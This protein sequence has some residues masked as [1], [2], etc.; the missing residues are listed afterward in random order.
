LQHLERL[1]TRILEA[2]ERGLLRLIGS[3]RGGE[4]CSDRV[5]ALTDWPI[6]QI[7]KASSQPRR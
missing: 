3:N 4:V 7:A 6:E 5:S 1:G 2:V